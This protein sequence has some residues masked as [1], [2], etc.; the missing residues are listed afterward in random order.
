MCVSVFIRVIVDL[1]QRFRLSRHNPTDFQ[2]LLVE[3][4]RMHTHAYTYRFMTDRIWRLFEFRKDHLLA[5]VLSSRSACTVSYRGSAIRYVVK[6]LCR[7]T[8]NTTW[9]EMRHDPWRN[10]T[11]HDLSFFIQNGGSASGCNASSCLEAPDCSSRALDAQIN[12]SPCE[13]KWC[14]LFCQRI[15]DSCLWRQFDHGVRDANLVMHHHS[16]CIHLL[17]PLVWT[18]YYISWCA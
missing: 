10:I 4:S 1:P 18:T 15:S 14:R 9:F 3:Y 16:C 7:E 6:Y 13:G 17:H 8:V 12:V 2:N 5:G 11:S